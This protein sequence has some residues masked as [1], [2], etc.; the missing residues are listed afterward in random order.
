MGP[1]DQLTEPRQFRIRQTVAPV[2]G[3]LKG[4]SRI[5]GQLRQT[6]C[7]RLGVLGNEGHDCFEIVY[8]GVG[9]DYRASHLERRF[10]TCSWLVTRP[11]RG[12]LHAALDLLPDVQLVLHVFERCSRLGASSPTPERPS[13]RDP[14]PDLAEYYHASPRPLRSSM[15]RLTPRSA[16]RAAVSSRRGPWQLHLVVMPP[17]ECPSD[18]PGLRRGYS[19][20]SE[21]R[22]IW[23]PAPL[24]PVAQSGNAD[25]DHEGELSLRLVELAPDGLHIG[26]IE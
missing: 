24:L 11:R 15:S 13:S 18:R 23:G 12:R 9:P 7:V 25:A 8:R 17:P 3:T 6:A 2:G 22:P 20:E 5:D 21:R 26:R 16:A 4:L 19:Q 14:W 1:D 10:F